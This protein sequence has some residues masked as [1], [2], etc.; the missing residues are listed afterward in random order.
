MAT[1]A[2]CAQKHGGVKKKEKKRDALWN[3]FT[4]I[5]I[6]PSEVIHFSV[7]R[8]HKKLILSR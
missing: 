4:F 7:M 2:Q 5:S 1:T 8:E 3:I 6:Q